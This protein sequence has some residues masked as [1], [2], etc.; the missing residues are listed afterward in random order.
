M[1]GIISIMI[2]TCACCLLCY[3]SSY[4][5]PKRVHAKS[6]EYYEEMAAKIELK[7]GAL[8]SKITQLS[9][10]RDVSFENEQDVNIASPLGKFHRPETLGMNDM[11][12]NQNQ[13]PGMISE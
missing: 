8:E 10:G 7:N 9:L 6:K 2:A 5:M 12:L 3:F 4:Q 13:K 11:S 1:T